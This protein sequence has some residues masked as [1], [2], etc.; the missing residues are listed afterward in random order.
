MMKKMN[1]GNIHFGLT[2]LDQINDVIK[3]LVCAVDDIFLSKITK[4][5]IL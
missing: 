4:A 3:V 5:S 1:T 2:K